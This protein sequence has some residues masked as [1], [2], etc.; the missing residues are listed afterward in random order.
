M[1]KNNRDNM[2]FINKG[3][4]PQTGIISFE[5]KASEYGIDD[6]GN[7]MGAVFF[8]YNKDGLLDLFVLN[9]EQSKTIPTNYRKKI[10]D[11]TAV[12]NDKLYKNNGATPLISNNG[13]PIIGYGQGSCV[14]GSTYVNAGYF[15]NTPEWIFDNWFK[16]NK[17][18]LE[19][20]H[21]KNLIDEIKSE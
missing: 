17:T 1:H 13:G 12:S 4:D 3:V 11:G 21:F 18:I 14:G 2:L 19:Y 8:D 16:E 20:D 10:T 7:S 6:S 15:S 9:N 5:E